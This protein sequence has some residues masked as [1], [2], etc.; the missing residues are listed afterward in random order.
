VTDGLVVFVQRRIRA[1]VARVFAAWTDP[2]Q[3]CAWWGPAPVRCSGAE[4]DLRVGGAYAIGNAAPDGSVVWIRGVFEVVDPPHR[5][6]YTWRLGAGT[7]DERVTVRF[8]A[9]G[10]ATDVTVL[11][12]RIADPEAQRTHTAGWHGCLDGLEAMFAGGR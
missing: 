8:V 3:L 6:V 10:D 2:E 11:H 7:G 9:V 5:L 1:P 4:V 12:E